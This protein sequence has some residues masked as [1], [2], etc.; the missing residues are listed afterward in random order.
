MYLACLYLI[1]PPGFR[2]FLTIK[3][4]TYF[5]CLVVQCV[6]GCGHF[7]THFPNY[8]I[9]SKDL[10]MVLPPDYIQSNNSLRSLLRH[11]HHSLLVWI[12]FERLKASMCSGMFWLYCIDMY[13]KVKKRMCKLKGW[14]GASEI[15]VLNRRVSPDKTLDS[16][17]FEG[18][19]SCT[20]PLSQALHKGLASQSTRFKH[21]PRGCSVHRN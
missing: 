19:I 18:W 2:A 12:V 7:R 10:K 14:S 17:F 13:V 3:P 6:C 11:C 15:R 8:T 21:L 5:S 16:V 1:L 4:W 9:A 20:H